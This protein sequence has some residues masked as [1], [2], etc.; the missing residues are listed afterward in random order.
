MQRSVAPVGRGAACAGLATAFAP[1][2]ADAPG[3]AAGYKA[4]ASVAN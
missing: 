1:Y 4:A 3:S 2:L